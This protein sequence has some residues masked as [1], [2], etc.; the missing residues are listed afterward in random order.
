[1]IKKK[2]FIF[3]VVF[4]IFFYMGLLSETNII[5]KYFDSLIKTY[6]FVSLFV[7]VIKCF[8]LMRK[9]TNVLIDY[10]LISSLGLLTGSCYFWYI[11]AMQ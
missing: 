1:M 6:T 8:F 4:L 3:L 11:A 5:Y 7:L 2:I 9:R 10:I